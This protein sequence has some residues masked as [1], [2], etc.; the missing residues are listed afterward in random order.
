MTIAE[1]EKQ[2]T[3]KTTK[4]LSPLQKLIDAEKSLEPCPFCKNLPRIGVHDEEGNF[5]GFAEDDRARNY[6]DDPW[7]GLSFQLWH[8]SKCPV[9]TDDPHRSMGFGGYNLQYPTAEDAAK[10]WNERAEK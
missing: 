9:C 7:S 3:T 8:P 10:H 6:L 4:R 2:Q 1:K 5:K